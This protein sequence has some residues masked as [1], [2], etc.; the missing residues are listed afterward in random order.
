MLLHCMP[1]PCHL[2]SFG[3]GVEKVPVSPQCEVLRSPWEHLRESRGELPLCSERMPGSQELRLGV[4]L[5]GKEW[6]IGWRGVGVRMGCVVCVYT[7]SVWC[8]CV[9]S[10]ACMWYR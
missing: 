5:A 2:H 7:V 10:V 3:S 9:V 8:M 1:V 6:P 4:A